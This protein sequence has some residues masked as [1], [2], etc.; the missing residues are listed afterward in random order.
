MIC[1][2]VWIGNAYRRNSIHTAPAAVDLAFTRCRYST[3][4]H[5]GRHE[6]T[7]RK[8]VEG[9]GADAV[10]APL[11]ALRMGASALQLTVRSITSG[12]DFDDM[13]WAMLPNGVHFD[14][15][16]IHSEFGE[17]LRERKPIRSVVAERPRVAQI[18]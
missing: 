11:P 7:G 8:P 17:L 3:R 15:A 13:R 14:S 9:L 6:G 4:H 10:E 16:N 1:F 12:E 18:Q 2:A 5:A